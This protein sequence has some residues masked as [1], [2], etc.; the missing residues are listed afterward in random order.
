M[1]RKYKN[2]IIDDESYVYKGSSTNITYAL[3]SRRVQKRQKKN[4]FK[5]SLYGAL[6]DESIIGFH[7]TYGD[8]NSNSY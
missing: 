4:K 5:I 6:G 2:I 8:Y 3:S 7:Y 1:E